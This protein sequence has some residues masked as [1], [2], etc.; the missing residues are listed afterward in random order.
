MQANYEAIAQEYEYKDGKLA[1]AS[2]NKLKRKIKSMCYVEDGNKHDPGGD[3]GDQPKR[4]AIGTKRKINDEIKP[5]ITKRGR[6]SRAEKRTS[7]I[8]KEGEDNGKNGFDSLDRKV[9]REERTKKVSSGGKA[10][11]SSKRLRS[12]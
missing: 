5:S 4:K 8:A 10:R 7:V 1:S 3:N 9:D 12:C 11:S 6:P 2:I